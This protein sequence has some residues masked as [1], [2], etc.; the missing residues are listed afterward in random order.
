MPDIGGQ[1]LPR[2]SGICPLLPSAAVRQSRR[3][4]GGKVPGLKQIYLIPEYGRWVSLSRFCSPLDGAGMRAGRVMSPANSYLLEAGKAAKTVA[5]PLCLWLS[6]RVQNR[7]RSGINLQS[8]ATWL[9]LHRLC[10]V[11]PSDNRTTQDMLPPSAPAGGGGLS[12]RTIRLM[13]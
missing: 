13:L 9:W 2:R 10:S 6:L 4:K 7:Q 11:F 3:S 8:Q 1:P 5:R 12:P